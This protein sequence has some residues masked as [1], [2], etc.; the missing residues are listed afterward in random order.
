M[1]MKSGPG[2]LPV[3]GF[4]QKFKSQ[5]W[6]GNTMTDRLPKALDRDAIRDHYDAYGSRQDGQNWYEDPALEV[7]LYNGAFDSAEHVVEVGCGTGQ[8][9]ET[10]LRDHLGPMARYTGLEISQTM[11]SLARDRLLVFEPRA[12]V[13]LT[14]GGMMLPECDRIVA[15]YV[16]NLLDEDTMALFLAEAEAALPPDGLICLANLSPGAPLSGLWSML[17][18]LAPG[19]LGGCRPIRTA[20]R[21][22]E[23]GWRIVHAQRVSVYGLASET[24]IAMPP[25]FA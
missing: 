20:Q 19:L 7:L 3:G 4:M 2:T 10:L 12:V 5:R 24:V 21:L 11:V 1:L 18:R 14:D 13:E 22:R 15:A 8:L 6:N 25:T 16:M 9:A 17:Y 23:D